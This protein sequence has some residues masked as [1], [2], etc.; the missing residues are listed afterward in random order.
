MLFMDIKK[1]TEPIKVNISKPNGGNCF[2]SGANPLAL[3]P[4]DFYLM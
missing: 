2:I 4:L 1:G 3:I